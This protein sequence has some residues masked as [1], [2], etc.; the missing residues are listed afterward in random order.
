MEHALLPPADGMLPVNPSDLPIDLSHNAHEAQESHLSHTPAHNESAQQFA[1]FDPVTMTVSSQTGRTDLRNPMPSAAFA[2]STTTDPIAVGKSPTAMTTSQPAPATERPSQPSPDGPPTQS[3]FQPQHSSGGSP[4]L[5]GQIAV[6]APTSIQ[7][8]PP[9]FRESTPP[10]ATTAFSVPRPA[11]P[12]KQTS[13]GASSPLSYLSS[14]PLSERSSFTD[15][16]PESSPNKRPRLAETFTRHHVRE[17]HTLIDC[18]FE[19]DGPEGAG[20]LRLKPTI[21]QWADFPAILHFA[22]H[23]GALK[24][25]CFKVVLPDELKDPIPEKP[26]QVVPCNAY[27]PKR[28]KNNFWRV[29]TAPAEGPYSSDAP[30]PDFTETTEAALLK[31]KKLFCKNNDRRIRDVRYRVDIPAW[32]SEQRRRAGV[33][34]RSP[35]HPLKGD[36]LDFSRAIIPGIHTPYVY[37][38]AAPFGA[39][40]QIHAEDFKL[41]SLNHLYKGR[42]IWIVIPSTAIDEAEVAFGRK[43]KCAQF[44][45][46][47][48]EF[49]FPDK[50]KQLKVQHRIV[51]QRPGETVVILPDAYHQGFST[52]YTLAEAKNYADAEWKIDEYQPCRAECQLLT[53]IPELFMRPILEGETRLDLCARYDDAGNMLPFMQPTPAPPVEQDHS[54]D[55]VQAPKRHLEQV[56]GMTASQEEA[57]KRV[58]AEE[59]KDTILGGHAGTTE[60]STMAM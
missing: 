39:T 6:S 59:E 25:G 52:G 37:E 58:K 31:L 46:H 49:I 9:L 23:H 35:L 15:D 19:R 41:I 3:N 2:N 45:R 17:P 24:D 36:E 11:T 18:N 47:R 30:E 5:A 38:S 4:Q 7:L 55:T 26:K 54:V 8:P 34:Q 32:T 28:L 48:A 40:F 50:L 12:T 42:K 60:L 51:D 43:N 29:T 44:M 10:L 22:K 16:A 20:V 53:A 13:S 27:R 57:R 33:P 21:D 1:S 14:S 56:D